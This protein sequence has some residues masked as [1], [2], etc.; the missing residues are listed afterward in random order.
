MK[1]LPILIAFYILA[2]LCQTAKAQT[3]DTVGQQLKLDTLIFTANAKP[4]FKTDTIR[5]P[6]VGNLLSKDRAGLGTMRIG[7][8]NGSVDVGKT[9]VSLDVSASGAGV[10]NIP[11]SLPQGVNGFTPGISLTYNSQS[12]SGIAGFG[13]NLAGIS[14]ISRIPATNYHNGRVGSV[15]INNT[16]VFAL[17]GQRLLLK[18]GSYGAAGSEYQTE[19]YSNLRIF[20]RGSAVIGNGSGPEYFEVWYPDGSKAFYGNSAN[21]KTN[22]EY[23]ISYM[24]SNLGARIDF[25]YDVSDNDLRILQ[26]RYGALG[27]ATGM[28][29]VSFDYIAQRYDQAY[30]AGENVMKY[31]HL[32]K[33][34]VSVD[35]QYLR[36][37]Q[38]EYEALF[39]AHEILKS[40]TEKNGNES[41]SLPSVVFDY[42]SQDPRLYFNTV[43]GL[44]ASGMATNNMKA[45]FGDFTGN[46]TMDFLLVPNTRDKFVAYFDLN[47]TN[48]ALNGG[49]QMNTGPFQDIF[50]MKWLTSDN[51]MLT[52]DGFAVV[53]YQWGQFKF[54]MLTRGGSSPVSFQY[55]RTWEA[56]KSWG[57]YS[58][59]DFQNYPG[60]DLAQNFF[61]GDFNGDGLT[62]IIAINRPHYGITAERRP[63]TE[64]GQPMIDCYYEYGTMDYS[65][66]NFINMDRRITS[67]YVTNMGI[68]A[69]SFGGGDDIYTGDFNGD[70][71]TDLLHITNGTMYVYSF[72]ETNT[73]LE[74]LWQTNHNRVLTSEQVYLGDYNGDGKTDV[75]FSTPTDYLFISFTSTGKGFKEHLQGRPFKKGSQ[76]FDGYGQ[77]QTSVFLTAT[78]INRDGK[79]D[80]VEIRTKS[81]N[82]GSF[83]EM[84]LTHFPTVGYTDFTGYATIT[85][86]SVNRVANVR[87]NP[88]PVVLSPNRINHMLEVGVL[89]DQTFSLYRSALDVS[90]A[91]R[92]ETVSNDREVHSFQ[93]S[94]LLSGTGLQIPLYEGAPNQVYPLTEVTQAPEFV[95]VDRMIRHR[96]AEQ[97]QMLFG[98]GSAVMNF[99]GLGFLGFGKL[100]RSN[101][102]IDSFDQQRMFDINYSVP[103]LRGA[104]NKSFRSKIPTVH[105]SIVLAQANGDGAVLGN[106]VSRSDFNYQ[107]NVLAS[108][109]FVNTAISTQNKDLLNGV[110]S[111]TL[112]EYDSYYNVTKS[113]TNINN[114]ATKVEEATYDNNPS[115]YYIGRP[116]TRKITMTAAGDT[117]STEEEYAYT[118]FLPT[119]VKKKGHGT[120]WITENLSHDSFGNVTQKSISTANGTRT[121]SIAYDATGRFPISQTDVEGM[122][123]TATFDPVTGTILTSTNPFGQTGSSSYDTWG[124]PIETT[125]HLGKKSYQTCTSDGSGGA[126][127]VKSNDEGGQSMS[128]INAL[129]QVT[130]TTE[131][132]LTGSLVGTATEYDVYGRAYRQSQ[133]SAPGSYSQWNETEW[134]DY[135]RVKKKPHI[136]E[137]RFSIATVV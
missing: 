137:K 92:L 91:T 14:S 49:F 32:S 34:S 134:D 42:G 131:K 43:T 21:T 78:D 97:L 41:R 48:P 77:Q 6:S 136:L 15:N 11:I 66:V 86:L 80:I 30:V 84:G 71:K 68:L 94:R 67:N 95:V 127:I 72:N 59:C 82:Q 8:A 116:L 98:Y 57:Y 87:N 102:H 12:G 10:A 132:T 70:G 123:S 35:G 29:L 26:I 120:P 109:V 130:Q 13:W 125:N 56:P 124:R 85:G 69:K 129:G 37:Y 112:N 83:G 31:Y 54:E 122:T 115:G 9:T 81:Y 4:I 114:I 3:L 128:Y 46:G 24:E 110:N 133:P 119:Q 75:L 36:H 106:Y 47:P 121:M 1:R 5:L 118:G 20:S 89:S 39:H 45:V 61:S 101:W 79:T 28:N 90:E 2:Q 23:G 105:P 111:E 22:L 107:T 16:D 73:A 62:D 126:I 103:A 33:I 51:K 64:P 7:S 40:L 135:G 38:L 96:G 117:H 113:T 74:L 58:E 76:T 19:N 60:E 50:P 52:G 44:G 53:K 88:I 108:K 25:F 18:S 100:V 93:Y 27:N 65:T 99:E 104:V 55:D 17:D 63:V